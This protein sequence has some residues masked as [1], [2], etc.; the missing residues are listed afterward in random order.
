MGFGFANLGS[1]GLCHICER[2]SMT[3]HKRLIIV[4]DGIAGLSPYWPKI[5]REYLE[6]IIRCFHDKCGEQGANNVTWFDLQSINWTRDVDTFLGTLSCLAFNGDDLSQYA[7]AEG[8]AE[9]LMMYTRPFNGTCTTQDHYDGE[10]HCILVAAGDPVPLK[11]LVTVPMILDGK[12]VVGR[13]LHNFEA[14]F[15]EVTQMFSQLGVSIS[16]IIPNE[17]AI[18]GKVFNLGNNITEMEHAPLY[19]YKIDEIFVMLSHNFKEAREAIHEKRIMENSPTILNL[20]SD[21]VSLTEFF[22]NDIQGL[23]MIPEVADKMHVSLSSSSSFSPVNVYEDIMAELD[24]INDNVVLYD[25]PN[26]SEIVE[27]PLSN[28]FIPD[29]TLLDDVQYSLGQDQTTSTMDMVSMDALKTIE[30]EFGKTLEGSSNEQNASRNQNCLIDLTK[31][32]DEEVQ[33]EPVVAPKVPST[34]NRRRGSSK[35]LSLHQPRGYVNTPIRQGHYVQPEIEYQPKNGFGNALIPYSTT[36]SATHGFQLHNSPS[37]NVYDGVSNTQVGGLSR[38]PFSSQYPLPRLNV[39]GIGRSTIWVP[40][41][42]RIPQV[43]QWNSLLPPPSY[44]MDFPNY[45]QAWEGYLCG[46]VQSGNMFLNHAKGFRRA[47]SPSIMFHYNVD[48]ALFQII[49][50]TNRDLYN[51]LVRANM[52]TIFV[53]QMEMQSNNRI[54]WA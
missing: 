18:F 14:D 52:G 15:L 45:V 44:V 1:I 2:K 13:L 34:T 6:K 8:L 41:M 24:A 40:P 11:M 33:I 22:N 51:Y 9:A 20:Q 5:L 37:L 19:S 46:K 17:N 4:V 47:T 26:T 42:S 48:Y 53:E 16:V 30:A 21:D 54:L 10:K 23:G 7:M 35:E 36:N 49:E 50:Y 31:N 43:T 39:P 12:F 32:N 25:K 29:E 38:A 27:D 3:S 28:L